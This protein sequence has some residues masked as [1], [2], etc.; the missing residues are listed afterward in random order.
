MVE[1]VGH[2]VVCLVPAVGVQKVADS[3]SAAVDASD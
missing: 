3:R 1:A 2:S